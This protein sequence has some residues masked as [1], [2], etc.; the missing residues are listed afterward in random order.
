[1]ELQEQENIW[2]KYITAINLED[3]ILLSQSRAFR[4][5]YLLRN[6]VFKIV[7]TK[8]DRNNILRSQDIP[9]EYRILKKCYR[10]NGIPKPYKYYKTETFDVLIMEAFDG[11]LL[12]DIQLNLKRSGILILRLSLILIKL[13][14]LGISHNDLIPRNILTT[15]LNK[16]CLVDFDQ[17]THTSF[18]NAF[19]RSFFGLQIGKDSVYGSFLRISISLLLASLPRKISRYFK[20]LLNSIDYK[21]HK[22]P[23]LP[24]NSCPQLKAI[25]RA[26]RIAQNSNASSPGKTLAY[27]SIKFE[28]YRFP[29]ERLWEDRWNII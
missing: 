28:G 5:T 3:G 2:L 16:V 7:I 1:M 24:K 8:F 27:Y 9:G 21:R 13:S 22:L 23:R 17:A 12:S 25:N 6:K 19:L 4:R 18:I 29:G 14:L 26:W 15:P 10:V 20:I 11:E